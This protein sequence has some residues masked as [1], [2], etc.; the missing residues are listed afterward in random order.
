MGFVFVKER[1]KAEPGNCQ[2]RTATHHIIGIKESRLAERPGL[3][4]SVLEFS[5]DSATTQQRCSNILVAI[6]C[7]LYH[8]KVGQI[9][10]SLKDKIIIL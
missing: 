1:R 7:S 6:L 9:H 8:H 2:P 4:I 3:P 5:N 10:T